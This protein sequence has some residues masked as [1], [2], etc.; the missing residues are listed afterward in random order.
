MKNLLTIIA[1]LALVAIPAKAQELK[2][3]RIFSDNMVLQQNSEIRIWGT[4]RPEA[5]VSMTCSW[6]GKKVRGRIG[7][8]G[9]WSLTAKTPAA[10][11]ASYSIEISCGKEKIVLKDIRSGEVWLCSGQSNM[12]MIMKPD[13]TWKLFVENAAQEIAEA[14]FPEIRYINVPRCEAYEPVEDISGNGWHKCSPESVIWMSAAGYYFARVILDSLDV[15]V[16]LIIDSYGGSPAQSWVPEDKASDRFY[17]KEQARIEKYR[18]EGKDK[19][20]YD[21]LSSLF[22]GMINPVIGYRIK[23]FLWY[24]GC[25]N[26]SDAAR[27]PRIMSDI[28]TSWREAW[29]EELPFYQVQI[30]P[31]IYP[32]IQLGRWAE[33]A[34]SQTKTAKDIAGS[35][36]VV[37]A[38]IGDPDNIHPGKKKPVGERLARL[39]LA[40]TYGKDIICESPEAMEAYCDGNAVTVRFDKTFG[41]L[42]SLGEGNE[43]EVSSDGITYSIP[44]YTIEGD[45]ITLTSPLEGTRYV[46]Y[47]WRD[48]SKSHIFNSADLPLGP[49]V[50]MVK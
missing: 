2:T 23:G 25:S 8:D 13:S 1:F 39:A 5:R 34:W 7:E 11:Y 45:E 14:D 32:G 43:F 16:G 15:P 31:F 18:A 47:C 3:A 33:L 35:G 12:E 37:T 50:I 10:S 30:A 6:D 36:L 20:E 48:N 46:R 42:K 41:G 9:K 4:G 27:Y 24:Q 28:I 29:G 44:E 40:K 17:S 49:F 19:P 26:V 38:D 21:M 22:N